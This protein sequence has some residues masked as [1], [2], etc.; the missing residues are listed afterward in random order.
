MSG[1]VRVT[2]AGA[3]ALSR[4]SGLQRLSL[5]GIGRVSDV[6]ARALAG[7]PSLAWLSLSLCGSMT[8]AGLAALAGA[9]GSEQQQQRPARMDVEGSVD[10][11]VGAVPQGCRWVGGGGGARSGLGG[12][13]GAWG[14]GGSA[15]AREELRPLRCSRDARAECKG[16]RLTNQSQSRFT[17]R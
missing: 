17:G 6:S 12:K 10:A 5:R 16:A 1:C 2:D 11:A 7:L 14:C 8:D 13:R 9:A 15:R 3:A 4:L